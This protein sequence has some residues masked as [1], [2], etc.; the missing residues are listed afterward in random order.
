MSIIFYSG[1]TVSVV[2]GGWFCRRRSRSR[3]A[4]HPPAPTA[5]T[6]VASK[7]WKEREESMMKIL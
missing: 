3:G 6:T 1:L 4:P 5:T 7:V 2:A